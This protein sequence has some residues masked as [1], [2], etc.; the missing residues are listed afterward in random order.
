MFKNKNLNFRIGALVLIMIVA[1]LQPATAAYGAGLEFQPLPYENTVS[2]N[3]NNAYNPAVGHPTATEQQAFVN[4]IKP[5]AIEAQE[6][7][8][9]PASVIIAMAIKESGYGFTR[10]AVNANNIFAMKIYKVNPR[11]AW[12]LKGQPFEGDG[13]PSLTNVISY[14]YG[15]DRIVFKEWLREDNWY[16][17]FSSRKEAVDYLAGTLLQNQRY[18]PALDKYLEHLTA[19]WSYEAAS[20]QYAYDIAAAGYCGMGATYYRNEISKIMAMWALC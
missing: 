20:S 4:E 14:R 3:N 17:A 11:G 19:G 10:V 15:S 6:K 5:Y 16:R 2:G 18:R 13:D 12:Q 9:V 7:W 1:L 8:D